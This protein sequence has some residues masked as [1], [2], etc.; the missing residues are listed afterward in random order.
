MFLVEDSENGKGEEDDNSH[1]TDLAELAEVHDVP[2]VDRTAQLDGLVTHGV[3]QGLRN[4]TLVCGRAVLELHVGDQEGA[5]AGM[6]FLDLEGSGESV[7]TSQVTPPFSPADPSQDSYVHKE[8]RQAGS[9]G[10]L[11]LG[12]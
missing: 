3:D 7:V 5:E 1:A 8:E 2:E 12:E 6:A 11:G 10:H 9:T 4:I